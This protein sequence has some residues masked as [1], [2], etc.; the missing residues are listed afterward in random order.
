M[1]LQTQEHVR[2]Y[3]LLCWVWAWLVTMA[4]SSSSLPSRYSFKLL[5]GAFCPSWSGREEMIGSKVRVTLV[6]WRCLLTGE[7]SSKCEW[8]EGVKV[9]K[10]GTRG[11]C[12]TLAPLHQWGGCAVTHRWSDWEQG[13]WGGGSEGDPNDELYYVLVNISNVFYGLDPF[14][15]LDMSQ[16][17]PDG[18]FVK[19]Y[20]YVGS[21]RT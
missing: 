21:D 10:E 6:L 13:R 11:R 3:Y 4:P 12:W 14:S 8:K 5:T 18:R 7:S 16:K 19:D 9:I 2:D 1:L 15:I 17:P 20:V